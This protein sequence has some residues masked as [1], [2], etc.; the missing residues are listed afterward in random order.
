MTFVWN[1]TF[2]CGHCQRTIIEPIQFSNWND[3]PPVDE[4]AGPFE[5]LMRRHEVHLHT[6][7]GSCNQF[8]RVDKFKDSLPVWN[9]EEMIEICEE[10]SRNNSA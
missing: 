8:K 2:W 9:G 6:L 5:T 3:E 7:C 4:K 1:A 10:C